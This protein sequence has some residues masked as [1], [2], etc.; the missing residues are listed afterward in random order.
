MC[1]LFVV[2]RFS[3][4]ITPFQSLSSITFV[5][6]LY[7]NHTLVPAQS[8]DSR[9]EAGEIS[10]GTKCQDRTL[11]IIEGTATRFNGYRMREEGREQAKL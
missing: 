2:D 6:C 11:Q 8:E 1:S 7:R 5:A 4:S 3:S 10:V 9:R